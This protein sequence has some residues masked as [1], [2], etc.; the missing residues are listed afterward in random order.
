MSEPFKICPICGTPAHR[1][2]AICSTCGATLTNVEVHEDGGPRER[3]RQTYDPRYGEADLFEGE[4]RRRGQTFFLGIV[5][6][7]SLIACGVLVFVLGPR[8]YNAVRGQYGS[9]STAT[10][11]A[12]P[13]ADLRNVLP[14]DTNT[15][16][17]T[18]NLAT[19]TPAPPTWTPSPTQGPCER[20]VK[21]GDDLISL[22]VSCG[23]HSLDVVDLIVT[24]NALSGP[25]S[26]QVGQ[27]IQIPWPTPTVDPNTVPTEQVAAMGVDTNTPDPNR[28]AAPAEIALENSNAIATQTL[29]PG[30]QYHR[31][32]AGE[33]IMQIAFEY[34]ANIE[35]LSQLNP[36]ITFSQCDFGSPSGGPS[37]I[38]T[39]YQGQMVRVPAPTPTPTIQP[40]SN[41][42]ETPT[43]TATPQFNAPVLRDPGNRALFRK[44][45]IITLRWVT[46]GTLG[47]DQLYRVR[48]QDATTG[49]VYT[50]DTSDI[51]LIIPANWQATDTKRHDYTWSVSVI[52][53]SEPDKP[54]FTT[55]TRIFTWEGRGANS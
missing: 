33:N 10:N 13:T 24:L 6:T 36:E 37:C 42:S 7:L 41:G 34:G 49:Q 45:Q 28:T 44:D 14:L 53:K 43:P 27:T 8:I 4:L 5:L 26:I 51:F 3:K 19:V 20:K 16:R 32:Q 30:V 22:A 9:S 47:Q 18:L 46:T 40:T 39:V 2:A 12:V 25:D 1:N 48:A 38:V 54:K 21:P 55:E 23:H 15:P 52:N 11:T 50:A 35:I 31:V 29:Q 17:P